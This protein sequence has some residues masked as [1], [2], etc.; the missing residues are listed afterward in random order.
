MVI[1]SGILTEEDNLNATSWEIISPVTEFTVAE[2]GAVA[3]NPSLG[4]TYNS[5][6]GVSV[7]IM[8]LIFGAGLPVMVMV[9]SA[10]LT[11]IN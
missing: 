1:H 2:T 5:L 4:S 11:L 3:I 7:N 10:L 9:T 6:I 8:F